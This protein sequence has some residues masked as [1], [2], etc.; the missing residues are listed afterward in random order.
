MSGRLRADTAQSVDQGIANPL[1]D[2][3]HHAGGRVPPCAG[4]R[5]SCGREQ[6]ESGDATKGLPTQIRQPSST[7]EVWRLNLVPKV[8]SP[9]T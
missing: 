5:E 4:H 2:T 8:R 6:G 9:V 1:R 7:L 3:V